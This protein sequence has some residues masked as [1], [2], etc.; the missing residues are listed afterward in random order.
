MRDSSFRTFLEAVSDKNGEGLVIERKLYD[1]HPSLPPIEQG[2]NHVAVT[3][4][5]DAETSKRLDRDNPS[6]LKI[7]W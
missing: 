1:R 7:K 4:L 3:I 6:V 5:V 2:I